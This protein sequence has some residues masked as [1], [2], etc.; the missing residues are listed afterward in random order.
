M[1]H[2]SQLDT[3]ANMSELISWIAHE[4]GQP[5]QVLTINVKLIEIAMQ[6][7][8]PLVKNL[9][10]QV[11]DSVQEL[12]QILLKL[13]ALEVAQTCSHSKQQSSLMPI[14]TEQGK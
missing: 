13:R 14:K 6:E 10:R 3:P 8:E 2:D 11:S 5:L 9:G 4:M 7:Q 12:E 1:R